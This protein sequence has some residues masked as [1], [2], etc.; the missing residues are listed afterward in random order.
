MQREEIQVD[1]FVGNVALTNE[2]VRPASGV[3]GE[4]RVQRLGDN[5]VVIGLFVLM[6]C[7]LA[8]VI[9]SSRHLLAHRLSDFFSSRRTYASSDTEVN[10]SEAGNTVMMTIVACLSLAMVFCNR[11]ILGGAE[12]MFD[13]HTA[14]GTF[15]SLGVYDEFGTFDVM[16]LL[17]VA[18]GT[19]LVFLLLKC[20]VYMV[21]NWV[22]FRRAENTKWMSS[23]FLLCSL[24][25]FLVY[26]VSLL[27]VYSEFESSVV[28]FCLFAVLF[29]YE[30]C[31][32]YRLFVN[33]GAKKEEVLL[34]FLYFCSVEIMPLLVLGRFVPECLLGL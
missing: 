31:L 17:A 32:F 24:S 14:I 3:G 30:L 10:R 34:I 29:L 18:F 25:A 15:H 21:V 4:L 33:F 8:Y 16:A 20:M 27:D 13:S 12:G 9:G 26:P 19:V 2:T 23:F 7:V 5:D 28:T 22:F 1:L 11:I 6:F